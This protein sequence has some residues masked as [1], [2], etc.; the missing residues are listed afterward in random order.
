[1]AAKVEKGGQGKKQIM[2]M[3]EAKLIHKLRGK[4]QVPQIQGIGVENVTASPIHVVVMD[5]LGKSLED[6]F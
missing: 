5:L 3:W 4:T 1:M 6:L 2:L